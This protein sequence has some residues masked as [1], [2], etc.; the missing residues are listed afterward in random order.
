M[1]TNR[2]WGVF[3]GMEAAMPIDA[4]LPKAD[5]RRKRKPSR[6]CAS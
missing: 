2:H 1:T 5:A 3:G 6:R 4:G